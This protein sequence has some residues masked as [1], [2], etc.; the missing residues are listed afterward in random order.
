MPAGTFTDER[1]R[2]GFER[3]AVSRRQAPR[4]KSQGDSVAAHMTFRTNR[5]GAETPEKP[6]TANWTSYRRRTPSRR[7]PRLGWRGRAKARARGLPSCGAAAVA[8]NRR[9]SRVGRP[10]RAGGSIGGDDGVEGFL[11]IKPDRTRRPLGGITDIASVPRRPAPTRFRNGHRRGVGLETSRQRHRSLTG[12][13]RTGSL[14]RNMP[15]EPRSVDSGELV[16]DDSR[17]TASELS[18]RAFFDRGTRP[19]DAP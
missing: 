16:V 1:A 17:R 10:S 12:Q 8:R 5:P 18:R 11:A 19:D 4:R 9:R 3:S 2:R 6:A 14:F 7:V 15:S 13:R